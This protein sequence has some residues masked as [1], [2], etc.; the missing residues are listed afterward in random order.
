MT[1]DQIAKSLRIVDDVQRRTFLNSPAIQRVR[2]DARFG[3]LDKNLRERLH[4]QIDFQKLVRPELLEQMRKQ[5]AIFLESPGVKRILA[6]IDFKVPEGLADQLAAYGEQVASEV[7]DSESGQE[8]ARRLAQERKAII[9][10]LQRASGIVEG[11]GYLPESPVPPL[12]G[13]TILLLAMLAQVADEIL[14][15]REDNE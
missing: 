11:F 9:T 15:E 3:V 10:F 2:K 13:F 12:F 6:N 8:R 1:P 7:A 5:N 14:T 4:E